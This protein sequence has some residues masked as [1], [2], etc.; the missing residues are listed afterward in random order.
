MNNSIQETQASSFRFS[1]LLTLVTLLLLLVARKPVSQALK[2]IG[3]H[4]ELGGIAGSFL[5]FFLSLG[6]ILLFLRLVYGAVP[7]ITWS[8]LKV[9]LQMGLL[10][11]IITGS[12][13]YFSTYRSVEA[14]VLDKSHAYLETPFSVENARIIHPIASSDK[15]YAFVVTPGLGLQLS[16]H[17]RGWFGWDMSVISTFYPPAENSSSP[18]IFSETNVHSSLAFGIYRSQEPLGIYVNGQ[19]APSIP[20]RQLRPYVSEDLYMWYYEHQPDPFM[21]KDKLHL[22]ARDANDSVIAQDQL[23]L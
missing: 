4:T 13:E 16:A 21:N 10:F 9:Y 6:L 5:V 14:S 2:S 18:S 19:P 11:I 23:D 12:C 20:Y 7:F 1:F 3:I 8:G 17:T 22:I 15:A